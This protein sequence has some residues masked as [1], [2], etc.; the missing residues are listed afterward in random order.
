MN[1]I[2]GGGTGL[3]GQALTATFRSVGHTVR[4]LTRTPK[5]NSDLSWLS[6]QSFGIPDNTDVVIN[7][8]G[9]NIGEV[10]PLY[11][12]SRLNAEYI[13]DVF[14]SRVD[15][16]KLLVKASQAVPIR[17]FVNASAVGFYPPDLTAKFTESEPF[18]DSGVIS[19]LVNEWESAAQMPSRPDVRQYQLRLG[20]VLARNS[21]FVK[22]LYPTH[23]LGLGGPVGSGRQW[24]SWIHLD[25]VVRIVNF[26]LQPTCLVAPGPV[27]TTAPQA[28]RQAALARAFCEALDAPKLPFGP[29]AT[30][31]FVAKLML[32]SERAT[33]LLDGQ[34][35]IPEKLLE[36][37]YRFKY[38]RLEDAL[39]VV[40]GRRPAPVLQE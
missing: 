27:N 12:L 4:I 18:K 5:A 25:D 28:C 6:I 11:L 26:L 33:L 1:I 34:N 36:A 17:T 40:F 19:R 7:L 10:N 38:P 39:E 2:I 16:T 14:A 13:K 20:V 21:N 32:G 24:I 29:L 30:P 9:R 23:R 15:T 35:V 22:A 3:I 31:S 8:S 37:G